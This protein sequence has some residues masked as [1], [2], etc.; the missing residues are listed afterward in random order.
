MIRKLAAFIKQ[1]KK[2]SILTPVCMIGEVFMETLIP[3][4]MAAL[5]DHLC[6]DCRAVGID[7]TPPYKVAGW[8]QAA[9][10]GGGGP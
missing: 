9:P 2:D 4:I 10:A 3:Y 8:E 7:P 5:I 6:Q 1:Y